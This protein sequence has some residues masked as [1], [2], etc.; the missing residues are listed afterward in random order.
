PEILTL[1]QDEIHVW[2]ATLDRPLWYVESL[3]QTLAADERTRAQ[4]FYFQKDRTHFIVARGVLRAILGRYLDKQPQTLRFCYNKYGKPGLE[5]ETDSNALYFNASHSHGLA[6]YAIARNADIGVD[7][8]YMRANMEYTQIAERFF[9][10]YEVDMLRAVPPQMQDK[11]FFNC[12]TR[13]EAYIKA[14]GMG[15]SLDLNLFDV[16]LTPGVPAAILNIREEEQDIACWSLYALPIDPGY[17]AALAVKGHPGS[18]ECWQWED[19]R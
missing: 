14:R 5:G 1:D 15:L 12:W 9:S 4:R 16:S 7:V 11:A 18:I 10:P 17:A 3:E 2:R 13:K 8:E 19:A 6:L